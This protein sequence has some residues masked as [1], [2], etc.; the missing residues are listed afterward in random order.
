MV[1]CSG[2]PP[3][4]GVTVDPLP[5]PPPT[6]Y[7]SWGQMWTIAHREAT[8]PLP[9]PYWREYHLD[10]EWFESEAMRLEVARTALNSRITANLASASCN[11]DIRS[12]LSLVLESCESERKGLVKALRQH[13]RTRDLPSARLEEGSRA[14]V[15]RSNE[16][17]LMALFTSV[18]ECIQEARDVLDRGRLPVQQLA[19]LLVAVDRFYA[20]HSLVGRGTV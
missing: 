10:G 12:L 4:V 13:L 17:F 14:R 15:G 19:S 3:E 2:N 8:R 1:T 9:L 20:P 11:E 6:T 16:K 18:K 7:Y 5:P